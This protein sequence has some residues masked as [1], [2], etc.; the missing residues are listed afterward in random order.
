M[1]TTYDGRQVMLWNCAIG[2][3]VSISLLLSVSEEAVKAIY[4]VMSPILFQGPRLTMQQVKHYII[5][6]LYGDHEVTEYQI[7]F[8]FNT[9]LYSRLQ[10]SRITTSF[11]MAVCNS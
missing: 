7:S 1:E 8:P 5:H 9:G 4:G 3:V 11:R 6:A 2:G 10:L